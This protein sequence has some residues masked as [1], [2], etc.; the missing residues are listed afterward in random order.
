MTVTKDNT[1]DPFSG[2]KLFLTLMA[3]GL[4]IW[5]KQSWFYCDELF[6]PAPLYF[7]PAHCPL[8]GF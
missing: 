4:L 6:T 7:L 8:L 5:G 2:I 1:N 3:V